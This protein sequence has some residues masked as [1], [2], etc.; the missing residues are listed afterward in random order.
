MEKERE[1]SQLTLTDVFWGIGAAVLAAAT[2]PFFVALAMLT[3]PLLLVAGAATYL[4][5][6]YAARKISDA[7][8]DAADSAEQ[9]TID[10]YF[11]K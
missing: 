4:A 2:I 5:A 7:M 6:S 8:E 3:L 10:V 1:E 9:E 11:V